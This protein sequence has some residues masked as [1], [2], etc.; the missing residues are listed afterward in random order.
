MR[1]TLLL[2]AGCGVSDNKLLADLDEG[3]RERLCDNVKA[4]TFACEGTAMTLDFSRDPESCLG[5]LE[6]K[7]DCE[8]TVGEWR[9]CDEAYR[10][11]LREDPCAMAPEECE[12]TLGCTEF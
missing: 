10:E 2:I 8:A 4:E 12:W 1:W 5:E 7:E 9:A 6:V 3:E 11:V